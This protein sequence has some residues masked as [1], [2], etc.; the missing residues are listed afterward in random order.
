MDGRRRARRLGVTMRQAPAQGYRELRDALARD[1]HAFLA[2]ALPEVAWTPIPNVGAAARRFADSWGLDGLVLTGGEDVG[3][4]AARDRTEAEL[5][6]RFLKRR[7]P[8]LGVCRGLQFMQRHFGGPLARIPGD[9]H[10]ARRHPVELIGRSIPV[11]GRRG[12]L[13]VN[14]YHGIGIR[15]D[16]LAAPFRAFAI[17]ADGFVEG[18]VVPGAA[19]VGVMW[20]PERE[21]PFKSFDRALVRWLFGY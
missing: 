1:W 19:I 20:H 3:K 17:S 21:R 9:A 10:V 5:L 16:D 12:S 6:D 8:V 2:A 13:S 18:A 15:Q 7:Q 14:S 4:V 11:T